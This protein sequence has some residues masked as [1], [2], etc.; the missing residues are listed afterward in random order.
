M[1]SWKVSSLPL[2]LAI[3]TWRPGREKRRGC[4]SYSVSTGPSQ[5]LFQVLGRDLPQ[6]LPQHQFSSVN[7]TEGA[8]RFQ[9]NDFASPR[10]SA[11]PLPNLP[12]WHPQGTSEVSA[13]RL[14]PQGTRMNC[15]LC[16]C[17]HLVPD[18]AGTLRRN[19]T[20]EMATG[21]ASGQRCLCRQKDSS[22]R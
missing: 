3:S 10:L 1:D 12:T 22:P 2:N 8:N 16:C 15:R 4:P 5:T 17:H 9:D 21:L 6:H 18:D 19:A 7:S 14:L 11:P 13:I 20:R